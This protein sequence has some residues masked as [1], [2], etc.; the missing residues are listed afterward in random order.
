MTKMEK[1][2]KMDKIGQKDCYVLIITAASTP[3]EV[4][5]L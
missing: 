3:G 5:I 1:W 2:T 4:N